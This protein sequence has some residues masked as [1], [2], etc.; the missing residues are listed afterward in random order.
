MGKQFA[1]TFINLIRTGTAVA[2]VTGTLARQNI[3]TRQSTRCFFRRD[4]NENA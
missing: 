2:Q 4:R 3:G 1:A